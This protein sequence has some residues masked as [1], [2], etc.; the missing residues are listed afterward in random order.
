MIWAV[1]PFKPSEN[2]TSAYATLLHPDS[3]WDVRLVQAPT[4]GRV[5]ANPSMRLVVP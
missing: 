5:L 4:V 3:R 1:W 2:T